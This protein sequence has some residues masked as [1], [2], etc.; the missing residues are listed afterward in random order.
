MGINHL[1]PTKQINI[2]RL[3]NLFDVG[4]GLDDSVFNSLHIHCFHDRIMFSKF[5]FHDGKYDNL[6]KANIGNTTQV[7]WY[8]LD[9]ALDSKK[10]KESEQFQLLYK[11]T[12]DKQ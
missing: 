4:S 11:V 6:T 12:K 3:A 7:K 8:S 2:K 9:L 1:I 10:L 5:E